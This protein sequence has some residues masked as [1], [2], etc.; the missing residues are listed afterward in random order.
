MPSRIPFR[1]IT[2]SPFCEL[3]V[4]AVVFYQCLALTMPMQCSSRQCSRLAGC[5][6]ECML[7]AALWRPREENLK[8]EAG[9]GHILIA[10][11]SQEEKLLRC[12]STSVRNCSLSQLQLTC[13]I[14]NLT[15]LENFIPGILRWKTILWIFVLN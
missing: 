15:G 9:L 10:C 13:C 3:L 7:R 8:C 11:L 2:H 6:D 12:V 14:L 4:F 5:E 1:K